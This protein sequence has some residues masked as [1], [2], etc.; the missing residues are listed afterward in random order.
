MTE[1]SSAAGTYHAVI[2]LNS[3]SLNHV[4]SLHEWEVGGLKLCTLVVDERKSWWSS[5]KL[6]A[7][8]VRQRVFPWSMLASH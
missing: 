7:A 5:L 6:V 1:R 8:V 3:D 2:R 4:R